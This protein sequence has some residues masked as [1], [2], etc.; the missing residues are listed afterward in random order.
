[1]ITNVLN[2]GKSHKQ[3]RIIAECVIAQTQVALAGFCAEEQAESILFRHL[4]NLCVQSDGS[5]NSTHHLLCNMMQ[6]WQSS[7]DIPAAQ[8]LQ[9]VRSSDAAAQLKSVCLYRT[10]AGEE[11]QLINRILM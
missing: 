4:H 3:Y 7:F 2:C 5:L 11:E 1:M 10:N 6:Q 9:Y 8:M